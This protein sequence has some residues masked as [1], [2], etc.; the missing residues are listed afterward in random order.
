ML[1]KKAERDSRKRV[2]RVKAL[3]EKFRFL[4]F[5]EPVPIMDGMSSSRRYKPKFGF[6]I[7]IKPE[8]A[9]ARPA[10]SEASC[11]CAVKGCG[12]EAHAKVPKNQRDDEALWLCREHLRVRNERWN[13]FAGMSADE[14]ERYRIEALTGHRPTWPLGRRAAEKRAAHAPK[15]W[16]HEFTD[17]FGFFEGA[18]GAPKTPK[19]TPMTKLQL[20]SLGVLNLEEGATL[21][22]VKARY[23]ELV[24]RFHPDANGGDRTT[25]E[26][27]KLVIKA[28]RC[29]ATAKLG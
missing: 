4:V 15:N 24:K 29:L 8:A 3:L 26:R 1:T 6:D 22:E 13:F 20:D 28:Y 18:D 12:Q 21:Q 17:G 16:G 27:L 2:K 14:I 25:E 5:W 19:R 23:K 9:P 11:R 10:K 7:R